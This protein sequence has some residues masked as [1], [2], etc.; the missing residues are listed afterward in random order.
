M[1]NEPAW[2]KLLRETRGKSWYLPPDRFELGLD[3]LTNQMRWCWGDPEIVRRGIQEAIRKNIEQL[4]KEDW[5]L[6][7][8]KCGQLKLHPNLLELPLKLQ[9]LI[10]ESEKLKDQ[11]ILTQEKV[12]LLALCLTLQ[13]GLPITVP[14][15]ELPILY[16]NEKVTDKAIQ[17]MIKELSDYDHL[18]EDRIWWHAD[19]LHLTE[20]VLEVAN[21]LERSVP[22]P[23]QR[24][25]TL[26]ALVAMLEHG[27]PITISKKL[28]FLQEIEQRKIKWKQ[29]HEENE[30]R[31]ERFRENLKKIKNPKFRELCARLFRADES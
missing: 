27:Q 8:E 19:Y 11:S 31:A 6:L 21:F 12:Q 7:F 16:N 23:V 28:Q 18:T 9:Q 10:S 15:I 22:C 30:R 3:E 26:F 14:L 13:E 29:V 5:A 4:P 17:R 1:D 25:Y 2:K 20:N 24:P